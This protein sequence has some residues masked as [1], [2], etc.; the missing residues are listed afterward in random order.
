MPIKYCTMSY[1]F[2]PESPQMLWLMF[3]DTKCRLSCQNTRCEASIYYLETV[4]LYESL[5]SD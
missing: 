4:K 2:S 3:I 1:I 5:I